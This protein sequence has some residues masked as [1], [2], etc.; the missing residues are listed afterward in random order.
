MYQDEKLICEDCG[1][2][3]IF[4]SGE[5]EFYAEK[6]FTNEP[7]RCKECRIAKKARINSN[8]QFYRKYFILMYSTFFFDN[9]LYFY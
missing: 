9:F 6:G 8:N 5:Q 1:A 2:E 7:V 3:F 4:T